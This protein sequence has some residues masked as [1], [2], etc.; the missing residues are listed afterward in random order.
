MH[1]KI[2]IFTEFAYRYFDEH[3]H[4]IELGKRVG[5][6]SIF[7]T[8]G[9]GLFGQWT[10]AFLKWM[11]YRHLASPKLTVLTR[12]GF[13]DESP[14]IKQV[15]GTVE[16]FKFS[17]E[18][19]D[20]LIHLAAPSARETY[21]GMS[22]QK[23]LEQLYFGT[24]NALE[25]AKHQVVGRCLF[26]SSGA[27]YG[28]FD[29]TRTKPIAELDRTAPLSSG[30]SI[31]LGLGK[32][33]AEFLVSDYARSGFV[34]ASIAR[35][36]SFVGPGLPTDLHYA[37]GNFVGRA[38][39]GLDIE[40]RGDGTPLRSYMYM[41]EA[42]H[43]LFEILLAG[44][45][46]EDYNVGSPEKVSV[47]QLATKIRDLLNPNVSIKVLRAGNNTAGNPANH[48]YIP[49]VRKAQECLNLHMTT[50]LDDALKDYGNFLTAVNFGKP[51]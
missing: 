36:F 4:F 47:L 7:L 35:A 9:T 8:G 16:T 28:G 48:Y 51:E 50:N 34:D 15:I 6:R 22:D 1:Q 45:T 40:I 20:C 13:I 33:V 27:I 39:R 30:K 44:K 17:Q 2:D 23:K 32:R 21:E 49:C 14:Y 19:F 46:G 10:I 11:R 18:K 5:D 24:L 25:F 38:I 29:T 26:V 3:S 42:T 12:Q 43:W 37:I 41:G 31:G